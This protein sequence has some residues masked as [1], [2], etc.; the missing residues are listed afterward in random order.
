MDQKSTMGAHQGAPLG[1][2]LY[3]AGQQ[4]LLRSLQYQLEQVNGGKV[5]ALIDDISIQG[6]SQALCARISFL[7]IEARN[8]GIEFK[9][10]KTKIYIGECSEE[11]SSRRIKQCQL[12]FDN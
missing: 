10:E 3:S 12:L 5:R 4:G 8:H 9:T 11:E 2:M 7:I 1:S 6:Q